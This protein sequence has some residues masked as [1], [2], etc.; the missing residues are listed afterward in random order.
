MPLHKL[1]KCQVVGNDRRDVYC[2]FPVSPATQEVV[3]AM[4]LL[5]NHENNLLADPRV[6]DRPL[7][8]EFLCNISELRAKGVQIKRK[9][10]Y[11][12][13]LPQKETPGFYICMMARLSN[14]APM[15]RQESGD[16]GNDPDPIRTGQGQSVIGHIEHASFILI[17][18]K[19]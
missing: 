7:H 3:Q 12:N 6:V 2:Q 1:P 9:G 11:A 13:L 15:P 16:A 18:N 19:A 8:L 10:I 4:S 5:G 17:Q 14:P